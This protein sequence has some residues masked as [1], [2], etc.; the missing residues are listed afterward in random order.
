MLIYAI[1]LLN[2]KNIYNLKNYFLFYK[3]VSNNDINFLISFVS[4]VSNKSSTRFSF[5][6]I[7]DFS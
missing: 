1:Y 5:S 6:E 3:N 2:D 4:N 7:K